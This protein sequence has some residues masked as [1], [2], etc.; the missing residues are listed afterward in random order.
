MNDRVMEVADVDAPD[1]LPGAPPPAEPL[2][3]VENALERPGKINI[4]DVR[5][6]YSGCLAKEFEDDTD[7]ESADFKSASAKMNEFFTENSNRLVVSVHYAV[8]NVQNVLVTS[9]LCFY[10][11]VLTDEEIAEFHAVQKDY[12]QEIDRRKEQRLELQRK[13]KDAERAHEA[14]Q[15][16]LADVGRKCESNHGKAI[17]ERRA[18]KKGKN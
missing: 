11:K 2:P 15:A 12:Q 4:A 10:T 14:E 6:S 9:I 1:V 5:G 18:A 8:A 17:E 7:V 13:A 16:R 3:K